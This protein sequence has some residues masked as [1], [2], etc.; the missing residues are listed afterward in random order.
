MQVGAESINNQL[1]QKIST[2]LIEAILLGR[3]EKVK[4]M[5]TRQIYNG[6]E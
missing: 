6:S 1:A 5:K 4:E 3:F 2:I